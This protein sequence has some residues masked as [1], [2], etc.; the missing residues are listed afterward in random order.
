[1]IDQLLL[2]LNIAGQIVWRHVHQE[3]SLTTRQLI[4]DVRFAAAA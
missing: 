2:D 1:M 3:D 4:K